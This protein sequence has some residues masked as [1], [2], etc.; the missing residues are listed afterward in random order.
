MAEH[1]IV[2]TSDRGFDYLPPILGSYADWL[3]GS[4]VEAYESSSAVGPHIWLMATAPVDLN[5]PDGPTVEA[6]IHLTAENAWRLAE[7]I[8][9]L[10]RNHYQGDAS[11]GTE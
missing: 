6:P 9:Y 2:E 3:T 7:Q 8:M 4:K 11:P 5:H 1:L 10:V